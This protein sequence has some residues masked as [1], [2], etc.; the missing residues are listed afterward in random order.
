MPKIEN[1]K[2]ER[3]Y[4]SLI[5]KARSIRP[6]EP[7]IENTEKHHI[8]PRCLNGLDTPE[9]LVRLSIREHYLAH[10]LL[11][12]MYDGQEKYK[13]EWALFSLAGKPNRKLILTSRQ[14]E[15]C[16]KTLHASMKGRKQSESHRKNK[17]LALRGSKNGMHHS[18]GRKHPLL[19]IPCTEER[20]KNISEAQKKRLADPNAVHGR[21]GKKM[22]DETKRKIS[23]AKKGKKT[24][25][26]HRKNISLGMLGHSVSEETKHKMSRNGSLNAEWKITTPTGK[27]LVVRGLTEYCR[28]QGLNYANLI[29][30]IRTK[31]P[32]FGYVVEKIVGQSV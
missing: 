6:L 10:L 7:K 28:Q 20:R 4:L 16:R 15:K 22:S 27:E 19:G 17:G 25:K 2:Y 31:K 12:R 32:Y 8:I 3:W 11:L 14:F 24:T 18:K 26:K 5:E 23:D 21:L 30:A 1:T 9:N 13:L 29:Y